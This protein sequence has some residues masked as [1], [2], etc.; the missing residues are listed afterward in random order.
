METNDRVERFKAEAA[1]LNLKAGNPNRDSQLQI[2]GVVLMLVGVIGAFVT[3]SAS[4]NM[5]SVD[6]QSAIILAIGFLT[7][8]I[9]GAALFLRYALGKFLRLFLLRQLY[10]GQ[11]HLDQVVD[12]IRNR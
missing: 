11:H 1:E 2:L 4:L 10:E 5:S 6:V 3:Y 7:L 8:A 9:V 12:A